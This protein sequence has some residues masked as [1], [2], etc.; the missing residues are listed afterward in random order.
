[1]ELNPKETRKFNG[2][3]RPLRESD[4][5]AL[6]E[7]LEYWL[8]DDKVVAHD[9]VEEDIA[10][11]RDSL[12]ED[13]SRQMFV[14][15]EEDKIIGMMGLAIPP[16]DVL[17]RFAKTDSPSELI[18][19]Y[20]HPDHRGGK[21]VGTVLINTAQDFAV[22][23]RRKEILLESGPRHRN[24]GYPFYDLQPGFSRVG[25]INDFYGEGAHTMVWQKTF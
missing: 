17:L 15:E 8:R 14:T 16:K 11:M 1:M 19:A 18:M 23:K 20:V 3:I 2:I 5:P 7:T 10:V 6:K 24:T 12:R 4:I 22:T 9:E 25:Q 21:G 13:S